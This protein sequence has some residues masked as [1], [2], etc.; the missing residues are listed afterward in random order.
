VARVPEGSGGFRRLALLEPASVWIDLNAA[1][2]VDILKNR[3][4]T[5]AAIAGFFGAERAPAAT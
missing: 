2:A 5:G 3:K 4:S 1:V